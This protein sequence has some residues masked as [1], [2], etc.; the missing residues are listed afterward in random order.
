MHSPSTSRNTPWLAIVLALMLFCIYNANFRHGSGVDTISTTALPIS[1]LHEGN[2]DLDE[3]RGLM[4]T[5]TRALDAALL[6]FGGMQQRDG[7]L[8]SSYPLGAAVLAVPFFA[9]ADAFGYLQ[10][11]HHYRVVGKIA[12]S[13]MVALSAAFVFLTLQLFIESSAALIIALLFGLGTSAWSISS[14]ELWQHGPGTLCLAVAVYALALIERRPSQRLGFIAG[15]ALGLAV[16]CRLLNAIPAAALSLFVLLHHRKILLAYATPLAAMA[17]VIAAYNLTT[18]GNLS[19]GYDAIYQSKVHAWRELNSTNS[20]TNPLLKGL[21]DVLISPSRGLLIYSPFLIPGCIATI[22]LI[23]RPRFALQRYLALWFLLM[24]I[25]LAKNTLWWGGA[26]Y[27]P[28]YFSEAC[29]ALVVLTAAAWPWMQ[30]RRLALG[31]FLASGAFSIFVHGIGAFFAPCG[32]E[33]DPVLTDVQPERFWDWHDPEIARCV[34]VGLQHG[35]KTP[36]IL[37]Y[38]DGDDDL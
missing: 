34:H 26:T 27:G 32:W 3:F 8:V 18:Y 35:F 2:F 22:V 17:V 6:Y 31:L 38:R 15:L 23:M 33:S 5:H 12:A 7:H 24:S 36:E 28:R 20:Y 25:V 37:R 29:V 21:A 19:G 16:Y 11:W 1:I 10:Q 13:A 30:R 4:S 9:V 14:Q